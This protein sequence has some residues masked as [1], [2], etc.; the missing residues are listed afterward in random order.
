[1]TRHYARAIDSNHAAIRD[2]LRQIP[3]MKVADISRAGNGIPDLL[4]KFGDKVLLVE[5]KV[6]GGKL[7]EKERQFAEYW[8]DGYIVAYKVEDILLE[9][10]L[11]V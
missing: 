4:C 10:G 7:T 5:V 9:M 11:M 1:M 8:G 3:N 2:N 6:K